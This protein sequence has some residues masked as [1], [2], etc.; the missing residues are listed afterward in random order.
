LSIVK[1]QLP[2]NPYKIYIDNLQQLNFDNKVAII[3]NPKISGLHISYLTSKI[4]AK[5]IYII[6]ISDG[7]KYK[8]Q[9]SVDFIL[10]QLF[11]YK[12][13]RK[14]TLIAFGGGIV[15]DITGFVASMYQRGIDYIQIPTTVLSQVD[16]SVGGKTGINNEFGKNLIGAFNQPKNVYIDTHFLSTLDKREYQAGICE[17][18]KMAICFD[19]DF[20][21]FLCS[22]D[23]YDIN[24][25]KYAI[26]QSVKIKARVVIE[27]EKENGIRAKLNYGHTFGHIIENQ[28]NYKVYLHGEAV[29]IGIAMANTLALKYDLVTQDEVLKIQQVLVKYNLPIKYNIKNIDEFY[30][31]FFLDKKSINSKIKFIFLY[32]PNKNKSKSKYFIFKT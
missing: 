16:S 3:T 10:N 21:D 24:N 5:E 23:L 1:V 29:A 26:E 2:Q 32:I 4:Q 27:D 9:A 18:I 7:E 28:T 15:G 12:F 13:D 20:F 8:N 25:L 17:I 19:K 11:T 6:T 30:E 22:N 31:Q 14:C